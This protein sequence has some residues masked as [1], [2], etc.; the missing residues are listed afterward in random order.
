MLCEISPLRYDQIPHIPSADSVATVVLT[1]GVAQQVK[2]P[3]EARAV[4]FGFDADIWVTY[5]I[6]VAAIP[7]SY[8]SAGSTACAEFNPTARYFD[9]A[10]ATTAISIISAFP[11]VGSMSFYK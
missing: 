5:G 3:L 8:S 1:S 10:N 9:S 2:V 6:P 11:A 7:S 4:F